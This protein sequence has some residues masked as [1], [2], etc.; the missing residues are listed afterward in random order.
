MRGMNLFISMLQF[1]KKMILHTQKRSDA[2]KEL[3]MLQ[4]WKY[5]LDLEQVEMRT[6]LYAR[7]SKV[8][9]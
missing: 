9:K 5:D 4:K 8:L 3:L 1:Q 2:I 7:L 6:Q